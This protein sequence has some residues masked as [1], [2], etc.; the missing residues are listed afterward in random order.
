M[1]TI[2]TQLHAVLK[3]ITRPGS[4]CV[5]GSATA[6]LPDLEVLGIGPV[7]L[8]LNTASAKVLMRP[9]VKAVSTTVVGY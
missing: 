3:L 9:D 1:A 8:P 2:S 4:F 5:N 7:G 6:P